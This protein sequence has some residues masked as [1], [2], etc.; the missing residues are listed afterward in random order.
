MRRKYYF[1]LFIASLL[2]A[3]LACSPFSGGDDADVDTEPDSAELGDTPIPQPLES[4]ESEFEVAPID[5]FKYLLL[6]LVIIA[7]ITFGFLSGSYA[8]K[9]HLRIGGT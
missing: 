5:E 8:V 2:I 3:V 4:E 7:S 6:T 9:K 1:W